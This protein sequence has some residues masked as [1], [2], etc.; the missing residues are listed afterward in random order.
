[1]RPMLWYNI[2]HAIPI[3]SL[4]YNVLMIFGALAVLFW[5]SCYFVVDC[6]EGFCLCFFITEQN[7]AIYYCIW[8]I[9]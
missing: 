7:A 3:Q 4:V 9:L 8:S 6:E 1:M 5:F 2:F